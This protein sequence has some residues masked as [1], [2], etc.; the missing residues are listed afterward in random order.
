MVNKIKYILFIFISL[1]YL[2]ALFN[3]IIFGTLIN[4][5]IILFAMP[6]SLLIYLITNFLT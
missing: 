1:V 6:I 2:E 3:Y 4:K 5:N